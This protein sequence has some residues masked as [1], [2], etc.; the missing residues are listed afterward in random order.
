VA[1]P[2]HLVGNSVIARTGKPLVAAALEAK[3][4]GGLLASCSITALEQL[5]SARN[6]EEHRA[7]RAD[8]ELR[9]ALV[10]IDQATLDRAVEVQG[11]LAD[12]AQHRA[13]SIP[14]LVV[15]AAAERA[16]LTVLHYD[17]DFELIATVTR[18]PTEWVVPRGSVD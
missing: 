6:G 8:I 16:G 11:L 10:P 1:A 17:A 13:A 12:K 3:V 7:R 2:T 15:A 14:D 18:Q 4:L 5:F 9:Y